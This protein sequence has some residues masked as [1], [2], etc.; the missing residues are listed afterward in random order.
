MPLEYAG[1]GVLREH[2]A[3]R[4]AVG[5]F[6]VSHLGKA[7]VTGPGAADFV[8]SCLTNDLGRI[9]PGQAQYTLCC[10][11]ATG[12]VVDDLIAYLYAD[13]HVFLI[14]N[15][16]NTAEVV[17]RLRRGGAGRDHGHRRAPARTRSWPCRA[18]ARPS[19]SPRS[20]LP[21]DHDY[22]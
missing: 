19:C 3:V 12:G 5:V 18:R 21:T 10:D 4:E 6:D 22:M 15:A 14:P 11:D 2:T 9:G 7:R 17:R 20:G 1:G 13:D 8:N 16:A